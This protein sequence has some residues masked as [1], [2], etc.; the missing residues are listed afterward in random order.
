MKLIMSGVIAIALMSGTAAVAQHGS[1]GHGN[2]GRG[3]Q[4]HGNQGHGDQGRDNR[5]P[6]NQVRGNMGRSDNGRHL[7]WSKDRGN[8]HRWSRGQRMGY[9]DWNGAS[10][11]D[12]RRYNLRQPPRGYEWRRQNDQFILGA[13]ATGLIASIII[14]TGR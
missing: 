6:G 5:G 7:G 4:S 8:S 10:R 1:Q 9:N 12:Y 11:I 14:S 13:I 3:N 2:E